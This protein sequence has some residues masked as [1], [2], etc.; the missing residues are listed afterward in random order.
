MISLSKGIPTLIH[1]DS[2]LSCEKLGVIR[3]S[4]QRVSV[5]TRLKTG[6]GGSGTQGHPTLDSRQKCS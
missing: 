6:T 4:S 1:G 3:T 5:K 2:R